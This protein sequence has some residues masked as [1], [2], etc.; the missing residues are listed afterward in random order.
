MGSSSGQSSGSNN[1]AVAGVAIAALLG[2]AI[3][4]NKNKDRD[5]DRY[6]DRYNQN[7]N[8]DYGGGGYRPGH[9]GGYN[10]IAVIRCES[11]NNNLTNCAVP[12]N[13]P[14]EVYRQVSGTPCRYGST[15]GTQPG[16][17]WVTNGCRA[18]FAVY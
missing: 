1:G 17:I 5:D 4:A 2:A 13:G 15:W 9:G 10:P 18:D 6:D 7:Y 14:V 3:L 11:K 8:P 16:S 12:R